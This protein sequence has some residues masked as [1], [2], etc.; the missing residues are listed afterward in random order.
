MLV[1]DSLDELRVHC[2]EPT[3]T[4][5]RCPICS[6]I[7]EHCCRELVSSLVSDY[8]VDYG[9]DGGGVDTVPPQV[10]QLQTVTDGPGG[11]ALVR[12]PTCHRLYHHKTNY[13]HIGARTYN[14][15][16][17]DRVDV[18]AFFRSDAARTFVRQIRP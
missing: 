7:P 2:G 13:E 1:F 5:D 18:D 3:M 10:A 17:Y 6:A 8:D 16:R 9:G 11:E 4:L 15:S 14:T 12:C